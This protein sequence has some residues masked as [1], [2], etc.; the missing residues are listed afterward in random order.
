MYKYK[1]ITCSET[2]TSYDKNNGKL[3]MQVKMYPEGK[4]ECL[5][6]DHEQQLSRL[7]QPYVSSASFVLR[8]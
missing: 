7:S 4:K 6:L 8:N 2:A 5:V 1:V 3:P